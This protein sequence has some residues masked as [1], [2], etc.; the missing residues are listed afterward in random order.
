MRESSCAPAGA[1]PALCRHT[2][3]CRSRPASGNSRAKLAG[4]NFSTRLWD[5]TH[6]AD[7]T[8][9]PLRISRRCILQ[10]H[11]FE[12]CCGSS[13]H[14]LNRRQHV[15]CLRQF[16][17]ALQPGSSAATK[18]TTL[19]KQ[20]PKGPKMLDLTWL[21]RRARGVLRRLGYLT[22]L[23]AL[24]LA[25]VPLHRVRAQ[26]DRACG[27]APASLID[28]VGSKPTAAAGSPPCRGPGGGCA[29]GTNEPWA[30]RTQYAVLGYRVEGDT[31][32]A[33]VQLRAT[34]ST[35][36]SSGRPHAKLQRP[37]RCEPGLG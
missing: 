15:Y 10:R 29:L 6:D 1:A 37:G 16:C 5:P 14:W 33:T 7:F 31:V 24:W 11:L 28:P 13:H 30:D 17:H 27:R 4:S 23:A 36:I 19:E 22:L 8:T 26:C 2:T 9:D 21:D 34:K 20:Q 12:N 25:A 3:L 35:F 18:N 32:H